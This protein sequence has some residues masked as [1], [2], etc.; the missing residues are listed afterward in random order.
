MGVTRMQIL[1]TEEQA[2]RLRD[3]SRERR[4]SISALVREMVEQAFQEEQERLLKQQEA[5]LEDIRAVHRALEAAGVPSMSGEEIAEMIRNMRE[6]RTDEI[7]SNIL[8]R[9]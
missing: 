7:V 2:A 9:D 5:A 1:L 6:E 4:A 8:G 3:M